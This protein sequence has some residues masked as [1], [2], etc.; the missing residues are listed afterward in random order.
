MDYESYIKPELLVLVLVMYLIGLWIKKSA[1][2]DKW[3]PAIL[4]GLSIVLCVVWVLAT[5]EIAGWRDVA[6][7]IFTGIVQGILVAGAS[8]YA[9]QIAKQATKDE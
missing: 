3:I 1:L 7:H 5:G 4:G 2:P 6:L 8:V 9:N